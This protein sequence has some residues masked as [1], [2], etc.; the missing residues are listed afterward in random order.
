MRSAPIP[1]TR[2]VRPEPHGAH[3]QHLDEALRGIESVVRR[4]D[5]ASMPRW[6]RSYWDEEDITFLWEVRDDGWIARSVELAGPKRRPR[7]AAALYELIRTRDTGGIRA[8]RSPSPDIS[9]HHVGTLAMSPDV[10]VLQIDLGVPVLLSEQHLNLAGSSPIRVI[11]QVRVDLPGDDETL[12][13]LEGKHGPP[14]TLA[15]VDVA[16]VPAA[17]LLRLEHGLGQ[18]GLADVVADPPRVEAL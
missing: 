10:T 2:A 5:D 12:R 8:V 6:V 1:I 15:A 13:R 7:A 17:S 4:C 18:V 3:E 16:L 11:L 9:G 14:V